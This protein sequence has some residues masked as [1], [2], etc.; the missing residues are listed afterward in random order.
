MTRG[1]RSAIPALS[2]TAFGLV[3]AGGAA[4]AA[5]RGVLVYLGTS[6]VAGVALA[7]L[8]LQLASP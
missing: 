7:W 2:P 5:V 6:I 4:G 3:G 8:G 1:P